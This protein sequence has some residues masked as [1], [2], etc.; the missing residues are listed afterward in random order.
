MKLGDAL[1]CLT[2]DG[3][4]LACLNLDG[5]GLDCLTFES[6]VHNICVNDGSL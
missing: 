5:D 6:P 1:V 2:L 3:D 4:A